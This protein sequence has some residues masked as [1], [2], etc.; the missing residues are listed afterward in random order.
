MT[1]ASCCLSTLTDLRKYDLFQGHFSC[2][3]LDLLPA[4][5]TPITFL[6]EP[7]ARTISHLKHLRRDPSFSPMAYKLAAGRSLEELARDDRII[8]LCCNVQASLLCNYIPGETILAGLR[9]DQSA[10]RTPNPDAF[11]APADLA[12]AEE[13][14]ARFGFVGLVEDFQE[15]ILRLAMEL[16]L[17]PPHPLPRRIRSAGI[18]GNPPSIPACGGRSQ[19]GYQRGATDRKKADQVTPP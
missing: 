11:A 15:D 5:V 19:R 8:K 3:M 10:G 12:K 16:G 6:R 2:G 13:S 7:V 1:G 14:L 4:D 17:H 18:L 9:G